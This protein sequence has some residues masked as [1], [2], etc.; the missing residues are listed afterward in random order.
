MYRQVLQSAS[1][2]HASTYAVHR[3]RAQ[4]TRTYCRRLLD[5]PAY[6]DLAEAPLPE[7]RSQIL[8]RLAREH[9]VA[10]SQVGGW[11]ILNLGAILFAKKLD[12]FAHLKRKAVRV[13]A[14]RDKSRV[15]T[16]REQIGAKGYAAGFEGLIGFINGLV[17]ANEVIGKA[18]RRSVPMY[19]ELAVRELVANALIHRDFSVG[20]AGPM[21]EIFADR[22][23]V[24]NPGLPL[25]DIDRF[26]DTPPRSRNESLASLL[27]RFGIC[28][29]RGSGVDKV[30]QRR[31]N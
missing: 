3:R 19:P 4:A 14:Y 12:D 25:V 22:M 7:N 9:L 26:L 20:G 13:I 16:L 11:D 10:R 27:R 31:A 6:F 28:E 29:E 30:V 8:D 1:R 24:T 23:E 2:P 17:P 5:Y 18:L 21:I 15:E